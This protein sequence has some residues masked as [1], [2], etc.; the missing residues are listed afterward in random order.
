MSEPTAE[1]LKL[2]LEGMRKRKIPTNIPPIILVEEI[3][4]TNPKGAEVYE[5]HYGVD[6]F[7]SEPATNYYDS[8]EYLRG[9]E[10][11]TFH[12]NEGRLDNT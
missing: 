11:D 5:R 6:P 3:E 4:D 10:F 12:Y 8:E 9:D 7:W 1:D 2:V